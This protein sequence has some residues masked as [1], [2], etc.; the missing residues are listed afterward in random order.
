MDY[1]NIGF[2]MRSGIMQ[3]IVFSLIPFLCWVI[4]YKKQD[5]SG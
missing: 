5:L 2:V 1:L 4:K 3:V